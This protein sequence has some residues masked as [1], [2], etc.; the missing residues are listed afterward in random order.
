MLVTL[1][2]LTLGSAAAGATTIDEF[3]INA[4][5][6]G[7]TAGPDGN[8]YVTT[9][10]PSILRVSPSGEVTARYPLAT[11]AGTTM[12]PTLPTFSGGSLWFAVSRTELGGTETT[13]LDRRTP[14]GT[15]T[16]FPF[17]RPTALTAGPDGNLWFT[18]GGFGRVTPDG[19]TTT[20]ANPIGDAT[21]IAANATG[22]MWLVR[23]T[24]SDDPTIAAVS[25]DGTLTSTSIRVPAWK[26][27]TSQRSLISWFAVRDY[28]CC[29]A[30]SWL[31]SAYWMDPS[32]IG[33][34]VV[35]GPLV[36]AKAKT[37]DIAVGP[38]GNAWLTDQTVARIGRI[39][40]SGRVAAFT[41]GLVSGAAPGFI[42][43]GPG[44]TLW[45]TDDG[46]RVGRVT[47]DRPST[48]TEGASGIDQS[49][50]SV[51][52]VVTPRDAI[53]RVRFEYGTTTGYGTATRWQDVDDSDGEITRGARIDG[54]TSN[55]TYHYRAVLSSDFGAIAGPDRT[56]TTAPPPP[57]PPVPPTDA[58]GD[59]YGATVDC[60]DHAAATYPGA[61]ETP[62]DGIDQDCSGADEPLPRFFPHINATF[63]T[64]RGQ[65]SRF[66]ELEIDDV[67][68]GATITLT[69]TGRG[70][71]FGRWST[72]TSRDVDGLN[73]LKRLRGSRLARKA[74]L[75]L[76]LTLAG[77][78]GTVVRWKVG[79]PP[80][81]IVT[82]LQPGNKKDHRC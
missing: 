15:I 35:L 48:T 17:S 33:G 68:A 39:S 79:P 53:T 64:K 61:L 43:D 30:Q 75:E 72:V 28:V 1:A 37:R 24:Y 77:H 67:P 57:P 74:V 36:T 31:D 51:T 22:Q 25:T 5:P 6:T 59:G 49:G 54:L 8:V 26:V 46:G 82:C 70:C 38:D 16:E 41:A 23:S 12:T 21:S 69:C 40:Q 11:P 9:S 60:D 4:T 29:W 73:L 20:F 3:P 10:A 19:Q 50:A 32:T 78:V 7:I 42:T 56:L 27:A 76:R 80:K 45:F 47:L 13:W 34:R 2:A 63:A 65:W 62:G 44:D 58:D 14:D 18:D 55:T 52:A 71:A 81:P 66:T